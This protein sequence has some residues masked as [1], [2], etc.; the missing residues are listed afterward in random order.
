MKGCR[1]LS[2]SVPANEG[3]TTVVFSNIE[4][5]QYALAAWHDENGNGR[6]EIPQEGF[7][8]GNNAPYPPEFEAA[9]IAV[10]SNTI[11]R[12]TMIYV[13][14]STVTSEIGSQARYTTNIET[15]PLNDQ[16]IVGSFYLPTTHVEPL[17]VIIS[18]SGSDGQLDYARAL[19]RRFVDHGY[20]VLALAYWREPGLPSTL[21]E[22]PLEYFDTAITWLQSRVEIDGERI[23]I[24]GWSKGAEAAL[25]VASQ[26]AAINA[27]VVSS[28]TSVVW[29]GIDSTDPT[30]IKSSW[31]R[32]GIPLSFVTPDITDGRPSNLITAHKKTLQSMDAENS[33]FIPI[34]RISSPILLLSGEDDR[35]W[36]A[37]EMSEMIESRLATFNFGYTVQHKSYAKAGHAVFVGGPEDPGGFGS[38]RGIFGGTVQADE[39]AWQDSWQTVL[40]FFNTNLTR[41]DQ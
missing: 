13:S 5:G 25:L 32:N 1:T 26:N 11:T 15:V 37:F 38:M 28:P 6:V 7:A 30:S 2:R 34:E 10:S 31:S 17:P 22:I 29:S 20:A 40:D 3:D 4:P 23:G 19:S 12:E 27:V 33:S 8:Y 16:D 39:D 24:L 9:S 41:K 35:L 18:L 14:A 21:Q 36:P